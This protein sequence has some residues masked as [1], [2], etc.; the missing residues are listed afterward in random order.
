[1]GEEKIRTS[2]DALVLVGA[3]GM[4]ISLCVSLLPP[5]KAIEVIHAP[6]FIARGHK[7]LG[8]SPEWKSWGF[9]RMKKKAPQ[10]LG[11]FAGMVII[12]AGMHCVARKRG[13]PMRSTV[14]SRGDPPPERINR[15]K[16]P[17]AGQSVRGMKDPR[18][19]EREAAVWQ[20][21]LAEFDALVSSLG[22]TEYEQWARAQI[23][24]LA[25]PLRNEGRPRLKKGLYALNQAKGI[26]RE[27]KGKG[28]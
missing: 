2:A 10:F 24:A 4:I 21:I 26:V 7:W 27:V 17:T 12:G 16:Q 14:R 19:R 28:A 5:L 23:S 22:N 15:V 18:L 11:V 20:G 1:M 8:L 9:A 25:E 3:L 13:K 6:A